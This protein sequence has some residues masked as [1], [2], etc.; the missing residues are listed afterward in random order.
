[1]RSGT[2][3]LLVVTVLAGCVLLAM[4]MLA[5][6]TVTA[7]NPN[8][9]PPTLSQA[10]LQALDANARHYLLEIAAQTNFHARLPVAPPTGYYYEHINWE[11]AHPEYG[12]SIW[13]QRLNATDRGIHIIEAPD[14][15]TASKNTLN[16]PNL[17]PVDLPNGRWMVLQKQDQPWLGLWIYASVRDGVHIEV[18]GLDRSLVE[19]VAGQL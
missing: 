3:S 5:K 2:R 18:D 13:M 17:L 1:M 7:A 4:S 15:P 14:V 19:S 12:F 10:E 8:P 16:L 11:P 6:S 9:S